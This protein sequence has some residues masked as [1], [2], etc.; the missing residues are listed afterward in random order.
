MCFEVLPPKARVTDAEVLISLFVGEKTWAK[1]AVE[2]ASMV[3]DG[4]TYAE[5]VHGAGFDAADT[6]HQVADILGARTTD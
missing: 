5:V 3:V 1:K 6:T 4:A 2:I